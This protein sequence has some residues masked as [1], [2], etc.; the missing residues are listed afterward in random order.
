M[1]GRRRTDLRWLLVVAGLLLWLVVV[2][3]AYYVVH[4][5]LSAANLRAL[6]DVAANLLTALAVLAVATALGSRLTRRLGYRSLLERVVFSA[7]LGLGIFSVVTFGLGLLG[8]FYGWLF[9]ALLLGAGL[10]LAPE[11]WRLGRAL[12]QADW[13]RPRGVWPIFLSLFIGATLLLVLLLA[14][15]PPVEWDSLTYHLAG[16]ERYLRAHRF[17]H[18]FDIYYLF[19][20]SFTEMLFTL[21]MGL[22]SDIVARLLHFAYLGLTL[23]AVGAFAARHWR[24]EGRRL[25]LVAA[26]LFL[27]IPTAVQIAAWS[28]VDLALTFYSFAGLYA[29]LN[30]PAWRPAAQ[31]GSEEGGPGRGWLVLAGLF[32]GASMS[33]KYTGAMN[34]LMLLAVLAWWLIRRRLTAR[35]FLGAALLV[36]GLAVAVAAP[37]YIKNTIV[38][39]NPL[40]PLVWGGRNWNEVSTRW[41]LVLGEEKSLLDLLA[42]PWTLT[43][44]GT[45]GT[46]AYDA[47]FSPIFLVLLPALLVIRRRARGLGELLLAAAVGY[48]AWLASGAVSYGRFVLQ[49]R[50]VLPI[51][52]PLSLLCAYALQGLGEWTR[53]TFSLQ[54]V[55]TMILALTLAFG[56][57]NQAL[58]T[59][60]LNPV[61]YLTG[62]KSRS[63][64]QEQYISQKWHEAITYLNEELGPGDRVLFVWEPRSYGTLVPHEPDPLFDNVSQL[65]YRYGSA[66]AIAA[67]LRREGFSHLLVNEYIY[68]WIVSDY[69]LTAEEQAVWEEFEDTYLTPEALVYTDGEYLALYRLPAG[70]G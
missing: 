57:L 56:W 6:A 49:G 11:L 63:Q 64:F 30:W 67:G 46:L 5:P 38:T 50:M 55:L 44:L 59:A 1:K 17:T 47:T 60:G 41:L 40:Y 51:F 53:S 66:E 32:A 9:W 19:F 7:G 8:L 25:G 20:P 26:A 23:G 2:Y 27:S 70:E 12:R 10:L 13:P 39:G 33:I 21:G 36:G 35:R 22:K 37:W 18:E 48:V 58:L 42:V 62:Y 3:P 14:L 43:V 24:D 65:V 16:P 15:T 29:L 31:A 61:P 4:K 28:Y 68:P 54:R 45:Q 34:L 69:P 52:A